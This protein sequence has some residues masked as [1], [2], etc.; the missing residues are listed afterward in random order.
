VWLGWAYTTPGGPSAR[1]QAWIDQ[2]RT[3]VA[4]VSASPSLQQTA[5]YFN[6]LY[7]SQGSYPDLS[8][9]ALQ[10]DPKAGFGLSMVFT[11]CSARDVV[12][13]S[14][15]AGGTLSKLLVDGRD[16]GN[17]VGAAYCPANLAHPAPWK[18][19]RPG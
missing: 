10:G 9:S 17:V 19:A 1:I 3:D 8:D 2:T 15:S 7:V 6:G 14:P 11:W 5:A 13:Q 18:V 4:D 12:I 16:F